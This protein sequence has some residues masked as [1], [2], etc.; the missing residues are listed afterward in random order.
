LTGAAEY[1]QKATGKKRRTDAAMQQA[2]LN[3]TSP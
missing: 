2:A 1:N 3:M